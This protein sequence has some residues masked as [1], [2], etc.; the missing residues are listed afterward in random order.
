MRRFNVRG[1]CMHDRHYMVDNGE[2]IK[3]INL[4]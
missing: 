1:T 2:K 4:R 3:K